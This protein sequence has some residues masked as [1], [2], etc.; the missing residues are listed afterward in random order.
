MIDSLCITTQTRTYSCEPI[1]VVIIE[2][3]DIV[4]ML[5]VCVLSSDNSDWLKFVL[6]ASPSSRPDNDDTEPPLALSAKHKM[7]FS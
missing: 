6:E 5:S 4:M 3:M 2:H 7:T 1:D